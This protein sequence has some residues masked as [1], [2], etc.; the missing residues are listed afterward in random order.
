MLEAQPPLDLAA[1]EP[2]L[3]SVIRDHPQKVLGW[4]RQE[5]GCW[6]YLAGQAVTGCKNHSG[7]ALTNGE[8]RYVWHRLWQ[9]LEQLK[10]EVMG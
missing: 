3:V 1:L 9:L 7:R 10:L 2:V 8:R 4:M 5:P 6:G